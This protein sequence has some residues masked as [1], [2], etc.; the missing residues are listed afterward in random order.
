[1]PVKLEGEY[2]IV[3]FNVDKYD[4]ERSLKTELKNYHYSCSRSTELYHIS[5]NDL[6]NYMKDIAKKFGAKVIKA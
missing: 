2:M 4:V 3:D 5:S 1:M 6:L